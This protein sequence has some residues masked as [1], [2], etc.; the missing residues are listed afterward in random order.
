[1]KP[2]TA[3]PIHASERLNRPFSRPDM[4][5]IAQQVGGALR[6]VARAF[7]PRLCLQAASGQGTEW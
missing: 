3:T 6:A 2:G 7:L 1:M 5:G 4:L